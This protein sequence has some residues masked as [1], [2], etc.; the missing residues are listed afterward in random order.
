MKMPIEAR[1]GNLFSNELDLDPWVVG[2]LRPENLSTSVTLTGS[3]PSAKVFG[4]CYQKDPVEASR[5]RHH[6][7][8]KEYL[9]FRDSTV[10]Y[11][12]RN[13]FLSKGNRLH[14]AQLSDL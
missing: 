10:Q 11:V 9:S 12:P 7:S 8:G 13:L 6:A 4:L 14:E 5:V 3:V 2:F 1:P